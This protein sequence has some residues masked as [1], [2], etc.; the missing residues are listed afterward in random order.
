MNNPNSTPPSNPHSNQTLMVHIDNVPYPAPKSKMT[1]LE[2]RQ[3]AKPPIGADR[4]LFQVIPGPADDR[5]IGNDDFV[6]IQAGIHFYSAPG[7]INPGQTS[8]R[9]P[10][11]DERYLAEKGF[12]YELKQDERRMVYLVL[13]NVPV[14]SARYDHSSIDLMLQIP[15]GYPSGG[16]DM[17]WVYPTLK[18]KNGNYP[19][20]ASTFEQYLG[21]TWQRFSR[22]LATPWKAGQDNLASFLALALGELQGKR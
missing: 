11:G 22:H 5:K 18:L 12:A 17:Y 8:L 13:K 21:I 2:L 20:A 10:E 9:L 4:D 16:L 1:G 14:S 15:N 3:L 7:T 6:V 19:E